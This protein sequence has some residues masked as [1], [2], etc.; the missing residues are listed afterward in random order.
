MANDELK[1]TIQ[2][3]LGATGSIIEGGFE[4]GW[5]QCVLHMHNIKAHALFGELPVALIA[6]AVVALVIPTL[7]RR[8]TPRRSTSAVGIGWFAPIHPSTSV[9]ISSCTTAFAT[10]R[11]I[12]VAGLR[13]QLG[14]R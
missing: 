10:L 6:V 3:D 12:T 9:S 8:D 1:G 11:I 13:Q 4:F 7:R 14:Q 5:C 2:G